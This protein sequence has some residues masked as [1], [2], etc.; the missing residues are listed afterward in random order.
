MEKLNLHGHTH[1][2][3]VGVD[4]SPRSRRSTRN[5]TELISGLVPASDLENAAIITAGLSDDDHSNETEP[6]QRQVVGDHL[7]ISNT[8]QLDNN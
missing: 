6:V 3:N 2:L 4:I 8:D 1:R 7:V 5:T